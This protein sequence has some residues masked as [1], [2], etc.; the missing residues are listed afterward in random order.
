MGLQR[1][2]IYCLFDADSLGCEKFFD[3][4]EKIFLP[5]LLSDRGFFEFDSLSID[6]ASPF[7]NEACVPQDL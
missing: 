6:P 2:G 1:F 3:Y 4:G 7:C 5:F